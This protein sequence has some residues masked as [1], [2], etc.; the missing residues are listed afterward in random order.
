[1]T[2]KTY[3][4]TVSRSFSK[5]VGEV[6]EWIEKNIDFQLEKKTGFERIKYAP[7]KNRGV[8]DFQG[9]TVKGTVL[10]KEGLL[11]VSIHLPLLYRH[12]MPQIRSAVHAVF[13]EL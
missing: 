6:W 7:D 4:M 9:R 3:R 11:K 13:K 5:P 1:M 12:F 8:I 2:E 10:V